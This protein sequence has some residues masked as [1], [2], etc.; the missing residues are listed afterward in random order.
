MANVVL[1]IQ[2][3]VLCC[4][5]YTT[6]GFFVLWF[7]AYCPR[8]WLKVE[9]GWGVEYVRCAAPEDGPLESKHVV[10]HMLINKCCIDGIIGIY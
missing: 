8:T 10:P 7:L 5:I 9:E 1:S 3:G 4:V 2:C 6:V